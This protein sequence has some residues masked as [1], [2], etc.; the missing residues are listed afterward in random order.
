MVVVN[1]KEDT[2]RGRLRAVLIALVSAVVTAGTAIIAPTA[3]NAV[4]VQFADAKLAACIADELGV[5]PGTTS[6]DASALAAITSL[7]CSYQDVVELGGIEALS[8][9]TFVDLSGNKITDI[10][11]L[12]QIPGLPLSGL[13]ASGQEV[14]WRIKAGTY[15]ALPLMSWHDGDLFN[16]GWTKGL[17]YSKWKFKAAKAGHYAIF[18]EA[19]AESGY[20]FDVYYNVTA[21]TIKSFKAPKPKITGTTAV[22]KTLTAH[23]GTW[24]PSTATLTYQWYRSGKKVSGATGQTYTL[25]KADLGKKI[26]VKV[27]GKQAEYK[28][29]TVTSKSTKKVKA[30]TITAGAVSLTGTVQVGQVVTVATNA[31]DWSPNSVAFSYQWYRSGKAIKG[32]KAATYTPVAADQGKKLSVKVSAK[33][34]GYNTRVVTIN[35]GAVAAAI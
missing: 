16:L 8:G 35:A 25:T 11:A 30:G 33:L 32:A 14:D 3:A 1:V 19:A 21:Y 15:T 5:D 6:F 7:D 22:G 24:K 27:T 26:T 29:A 17:S 10:S 28:T 13:E 4:T 34:G 18:V 2:R 12:E 31:A 23:P 9:L 20:S